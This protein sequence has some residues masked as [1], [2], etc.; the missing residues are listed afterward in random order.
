MLAL[1][2][3]IKMIYF[4]IFHVHVV[5]SKVNQ[6]LFAIFFGYLIFIFFR[7]IF[8]QGEGMGGGSKAGGVEGG[9][10]VDLCRRYCVFV[11]REGN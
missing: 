11:S 5:N 8:F 4:N 2:D 10:N 7:L 3:M 6:T 9:S 1:R